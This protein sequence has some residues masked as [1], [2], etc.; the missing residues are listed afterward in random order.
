MPVANKGRCC[1]I[2]IHAAREGGDN[3]GSTFIIP[4]KAISI[5]AAREG[6]DLNILYYRPKTNTFQSTPPV[7]AATFRFYMTPSEFEFQ[8]TPPV[9]AA[10]SYDTYEKVK[11]VISIHAAREGGDGFPVLFNSLPPRFQ[12]TPPV[13]AATLFELFRE[14]G[15]KISIHA[16]REG[17][18]N[19]SH[20]LSVWHSVI[21]IHA[22]REGGDPRRHHPRLYGAISIHA[23]REGGDPCLLRRRVRTGD[24][25]PRRP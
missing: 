10:T 3:I 12:S 22:A 16:A 24:F 2:S 9:K 18:D 7:K 21:S 23:A 25:N 15:C 17:G 11:K 6:G 4:D 19:I 5:H 1:F 13:K 14:C 8:S 20:T